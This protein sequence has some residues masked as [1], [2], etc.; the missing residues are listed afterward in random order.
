MLQIGCAEV[1]IT[2][3]LGVRMS[4]LFEDR[5]VSAI[6]DPLYARAMV[7]DNGSRQLCFITCDLLSLKRSTVLKA[8]AEIA[9]RTGLAADCIAISATH[10]HYGPA[11]SV[12]WTRDLAPDPEYVAGVEAKIT[13]AA[14]QAYERRRPAGLGVGWAFE[15][16]LSFQRR[17]IMRDGEARMHPPPGSTDILYQEGPVD[18]E[19]GILCARDAAGSAM[20]YVV[21]FACHV[22]ATSAGTEATADFPGYLAASIKA[23]RGKD[24]VALFANGCCGN[25]CQVDVYDPERTQRGYDLAATIGE[26]LADH[27][28]ALEEHMPFL[29]DLTLDARRVVVPMPIRHVPDDLLAWAKNVQA[30][31]DQHSVVDRTYAGMIFEL[32][33]EKRS[34]PTTDAEVQAFRLGDFAWVMLPGEIFVEHGLDIKLRSPATRTFVTEL[35]NG[36]VGYVPTRRAF[37]R[38]GYEQRTATSSRLAPVAGEMLVET[39]H[40]LLDSMFR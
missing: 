25:L 39:A 40:A 36:V 24:C 1:D 2:P 23:R 4:G 27:A 15:G 8:R 3:P 6:H 19:V 30:D 10:N 9:K 26:R 21:N 20:G 16:K 12:L 28:C 33:E 13:D 29:D 7:I 37:E 34:K 5:H 38:G 32:V 18:P 14:C 17:F 11:A 35:A 31:A 22:T